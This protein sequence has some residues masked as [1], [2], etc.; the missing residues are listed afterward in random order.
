M[1]IRDGHLSTDE[2]CKYVFG[3]C[4]HGHKNKQ[5]FRVA[6]P[7]RFAWKSKYL[8]SQFIVL[9]LKTGIEWKVKERYGTETIVTFDGTRWKEQL[10][11]E[12]FSWSSARVD[13]YYYTW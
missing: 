4:M 13:T 9:T 7:S 8:E 10:R 2:T 5:P 11:N 6:F 1:E 12:Q 3:S